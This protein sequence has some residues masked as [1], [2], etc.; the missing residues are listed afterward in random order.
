MLMF[1]A[2]A[3]LAAP[4]QTHS[5]GMNMPDMEM[6]TAATQAPQSSALSPQSSEDP[7]AGHTWPNTA[8][9]VGVLTEW[10]LPPNRGPWQLKWDDMRNR[11][12]FGEGNHSDPILDQIGSIDPATG[13]LRE[14]AIPTQG[15]YVHGTG[16]D[17]NHDFWF[18]EVRI[19]KVGRLQPETNTITEWSIDQS[20][21]PHGII[22]DDIISNSV[23]VWITE[24]EQNV[25]S[26]L[27]PATGEYR[28]HVHPF[29]ADDPRPHGMVLAPDH[30]IWFVESC[31]ARVGHLIPGPTDV[32]EFWLPPTPLLPYCGAPNLIGPL[33]GTLQWQ[34][35]SPATRPEH[36]L[37][38]ARAGSQLGRQTPDPDSRRPGRQHLLPRNEPD[39]DWP[40]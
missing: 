28:R 31:G 39:E 2:W 16:L 23:T 21:T 32:W 35:D 20:A 30:S 22:V 10:P 14:W 13:I 7:G 19:N 5:R 11:I 18:T 33:F 29:A 6:D 26:S 4:A 40:P 12:W 1:A 15:G 9:D 24:R 8:P 37:H 38:L 17:R 25:I 36:V 34:P 3:V 27:N